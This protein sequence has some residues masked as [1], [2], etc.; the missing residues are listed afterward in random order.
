MNSVK[1]ETLAQLLLMSGRKGS[2]PAL[3]ARSPTLVGP[4]EPHQDPTEVDQGTSEASLLWQQG[5][6][7]LTTEQ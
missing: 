3:P 2:C 4:Q 1:K 7:A 6:D 5:R